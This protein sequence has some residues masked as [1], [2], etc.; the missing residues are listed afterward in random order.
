MTEY[1][2][3]A[4]ILEDP[5]A[6]SIK[7]VLEMMTLRPCKAMRL[8]N[9]PA[10]DLTQLCSYETTVEMAVVFYGDN[11]TLEEES[12]C[13]PPEHVRRMARGETVR[14][15]IERYNNA[16]AHLDAEGSAVLSPGLK[17]PVEVGTLLVNH[18]L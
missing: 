12:L 9:L 5:T 3:G 18:V 10:T 8:T 13:I 14:Y 17:W 16:V 2:Q 6:E 7:R 15:R 4:L 1:A 11:K